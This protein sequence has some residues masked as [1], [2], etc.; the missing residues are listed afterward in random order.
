M[1]R[2]LVFTAALLLASAPSA[3]A[4]AHHSGTPTHPHHAPGHERPDSAHHAAMHD[5]M[6]GR[7]SGTVTSPEGITSNLTLAIAHDSLQGMTITTDTGERI[8]AARI[9]KLSMQDIRL[10]WTQDLSGSSCKATAVLSRATPL[11][12]ETVSG[13]MTCADGDRTFVLRKTTG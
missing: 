8:A 13:K 2:V 5:L 7:W 1:P 11:D 9:S 12:G 10:E 4:Q 6:T 3:V